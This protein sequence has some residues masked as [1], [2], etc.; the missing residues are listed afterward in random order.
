MF[1][2]GRPLSRIERLSMGSFV[3][4]GHTVHLHAYEEVVG[5]PNGV[6]LVDARKILPANAIFH[7]TKSGSIAAFA[8]LFRYRLLFESGGIWADA[9]VVC[10][11]PL[12]YDTTEV[13]GWMDSEVINN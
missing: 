10:L 12:R 2:H 7:H 8:D 13:F 11:Q 4:N 5:V 9:D 6:D 3:A 1:W